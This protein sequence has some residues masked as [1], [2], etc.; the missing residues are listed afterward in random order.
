MGGLPRDADP[1]RAGRRDGPGPPA[2]LPG[3][4]G[5]PARPLRARRWRTPPARPG[6][7]RSST[8]S[9]QTGWFITG[10]A[11]LAGGDLARARTVARARGGR[12]R[13]GRRHPLPPAAPAGARPGA[14]PLRRR[15]RPRARRW[16]GSA[17]SRPPRGSA[18][19][20]STAG[21]PSWSPAWSRSGDLAEADVVLDAARRAVDG[22]LGTDGVS[23]QLDRAE[24]EVL[25]ARGDVDGALVLLDRCREGVPR[26][27]HA[28]RPRP[29]PADPGPPRAPPPT[30]RRGPGRRSRQ[31]RASSPSCTPPSWLDQVRG[32]ARPR[33]RHRARRLADLLTETEAR[34]AAE[35]ARGA[36]NREIAERLYVSVKTVEATLTRIY[37][38]LE[39]R[40]RTQL[41]A[42]LTAHP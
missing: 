35:V 13:G 41:A 27:R 17:G 1:G 8:S 12:G 33:R 34:V 32:R 21:R 30:R 25:G 15:R 9:P 6:P 42:R 3:R 19:R 23:A 10:V 4:G 11:E 36:S 20:P 16:S 28:D 24:A 22:R 37:R 40:S 31:R 5:Q 38:K 2:A 29:D 14:A 26:P 7:P 18:T 39:V